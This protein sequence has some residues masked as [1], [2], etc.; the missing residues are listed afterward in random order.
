[1]KKILLLILIGLFIAFPILGANTH[2]GDL[3]ESSNQ[4]FYGAVQSIS[5]S[6][7]IEAWV[8]AESYTNWGY[9]LVNGIEVNYYMFISNDGYLGL[10]YTGYGY[11]N[12]C[13]Q[14]VVDTWYH[15]A[16]VHDD[17]NDV[18]RW[19]INGSEIHNETSA[20]GNPS[21]GGLGSLRIGAHP[22]T[23]D[24]YNMWDGLI[25]DV[26][27][28][29][30]VRTPTEINDNKCVELTGNEANLV[31]YWKLN[32]DATDETS[33][34]NDLT[35]VNSPVY[36]SDVPDWPSAKNRLIIK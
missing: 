22:H 30:D 29:D 36:S 34:N 3:E 31:G 10:G 6:F 9:M 23:D 11:T 16:G 2:S 13:D 24:I 20:T 8:K 17:A 12:T 7:T 26:R 32:D 15:V 4:F 1:M 19:Y 33:N 21:A 25:D 18:N 28:W 27:L 35:E 14:M 5:S